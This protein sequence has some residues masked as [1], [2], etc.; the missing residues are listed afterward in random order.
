VTY[1]D[2]QRS[3]WVAHVGRDF[4]WDAVNEDWI[5]D[6]QVGWRSIN[7]LQ[8]TGK[9][10]FQPLAEQKTAVDIYLQVTPPAGPLGR[11]AEWL[12]GD[13]RFEQEL[14]DDLNHFAQM[15]E[16]AP[17]GTLDPMQSHYLFHNQSAVA[18]GT[19]T[20][21]QRE[22]MQHD[23]MMSA[24]ALHTREVTIERQ[25]A[26]EQER[27]KQQEALRLQTMEAQELT[28][29]EQAAALQ[30]QAEL[31]A[32]ARR[33][34]AAREQSVEQRE[35]HPVHDTIGGRNASMDR[36]TLG[37]RDARSER[38][39]DYTTGPMTARS[40]QHIA[41]SGLEHQTHES[42][43]D[44]AI[45]GKPEQSRKEDELLVLLDGLCQGC[46]LFILNDLAEPAGV[47]PLAQVEE[48]GGI[49]HPLG[50]LVEDKQILGPQLQLA[51]RSTKVEAE[52]W[53]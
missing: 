27:Q 45:H 12:G 7:G 24:E 17:R 41:E 37:D 6:R 4:S 40:P 25:Q 44:V 38:F 22:A 49:V 26:Q 21:R 51:F 14:Q 43:W 36:T 11:L 10:T 29:R 53:G 9:V 35:P 1:Y 19:A 16:Q 30:R 18:R 52:L 42:P 33:E 20:E 48:P 23:P 47:V 50:N 39:P 34:Q 15:V 46:K 5:A 28:A 31:D 3:H 32:Q 13:S 2:E 8:N